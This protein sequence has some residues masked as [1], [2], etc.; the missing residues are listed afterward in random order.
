M[1]ENQSST[2]NVCMPVYIDKTTWPGIAEKA[3]SVHLL[4]RGVGVGDRR[5]ISGVA[6]TWMLDELKALLFTALS[7]FTWT[8]IRSLLTRRPC[9][10]K[11]RLLSLLF[12]WGNWSKVTRTCS[13]CERGQGR[14]KPSRAGPIPIF[15][16]HI[17]VDNA[18]CLSLKSLL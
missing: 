12:E 3:S 6:Y 17:P 14:G 7:A 11:V 8:M 2:F 10:K 18:S 1:S 5:S 16:L 4:G 13:H 15:F 9:C